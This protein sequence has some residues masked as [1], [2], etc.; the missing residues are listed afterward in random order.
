MPVPGTGELKLQ[1]YER[2][3]AK[4]RTFYVYRYEG[5][6]SRAGDDPCVVL[7]CRNDI[8]D[9]PDEPFFILC[10]QTDLTN[11]QIIVRYLKRWEIG[12]E[13]KVTRAGVC[14]TIGPHWMS[15]KERSGPWPPGRR[16]AGDSQAI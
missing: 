6:V 5:P 12:I 7:I 9:P 14:G 8:F 13:V 2:V 1:H 3:S 10:T 11:Q 16:Q 4:R 15:T